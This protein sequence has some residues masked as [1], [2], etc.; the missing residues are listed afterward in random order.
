MKP[1]GF[2]I[3]RWILVML[4]MQVVNRVTL[5]CKKT[6]MVTLTSCEMYH[7]KINRKIID[8][9]HVGGSLNVLIVETINW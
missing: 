4:E 8:Y 9:V 2:F 3:Q 1:G 5:T 7:P 6:S